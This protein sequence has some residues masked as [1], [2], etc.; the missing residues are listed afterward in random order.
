MPMLGHRLCASGQTRAL[1]NAAVTITLSQDHALVL[2]EC[3][4]LAGGNEDG[5][6]DQAAQRALRDLAAALEPSTM[7]SLRSTTA[8]WSG[9]HVIAC[10]TRLT[11]P[12]DHAASSA[13][14]W[15][16][17]SPVQPAQIT[18]RAVSKQGVN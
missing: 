10:A 18:E 14:Y 9:R 6:I 2:H 3:L 13:R 12:P 7:P 16:L 15:G 17:S 5:W 11:E 4:E 1:S 8:S